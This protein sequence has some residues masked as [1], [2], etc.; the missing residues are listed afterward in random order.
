[1]RI[2]ALLTTLQSFRPGYAHSGERKAL[3]QPQILLHCPL[4]SAL[5]CS[6]IEF[7]QKPRLRG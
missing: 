2:W 1:M 7:L 4:W 5:V 6:K 3:N